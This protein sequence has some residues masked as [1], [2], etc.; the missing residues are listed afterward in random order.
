VSLSVYSIVNVNIQRPR[1]P[2]SEYSS[3]KYSGPEI[4]IGFPSHRNLWLLLGFYFFA[5][6]LFALV[7]Y[8]IPAIFKAP[9]FDGSLTTLIP[10]LITAWIGAGIAIGLVF[11]GSRTRDAPQIS[12]RDLLIFL[13]GGMLLDVAFNFAAL[14]IASVGSGSTP[15]ALVL[16]FTAFANLGVLG[17]AVAIGWLVAR[18]LKRPSYLI[19]A[20]VVGALTDIFSVYAGPSKHVLSS[21][22]FPYV[23]YQ[24]GVAG[25]GVIPCVGAGD[26]IFLCLFFAGARRFGLDDRKTFF[27]MIAAFGLGYLSLVVSPK[28]IPALPFMAALL[29]LVHWRELRKVSAIQE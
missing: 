21:D 6:F 26:F 29:L 25:Q 14:K 16:A 10:P 22:V 24:W 20:A 27:A 28:G 19:T 3:S 11:L 9:G 8:G 2:D 4:S 13:G 7:S 18:G 15:N 12:N 23:S 1:H 5:F 17:A